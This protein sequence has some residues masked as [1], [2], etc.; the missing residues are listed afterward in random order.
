MEKVFLS[1][2]YRT[3]ILAWEKILVDSIFR[4][5]RLVTNGAQRDVRF[6]LFSSESRTLSAHFSTNLWQDTERVSLRDR[7]HFHDNDVH[8]A[9]EKK[10]YRK[11]RTNTNVV[12]GWMCLVSPRPVF[13]GYNSNVS[14]P[15][16]CT[17]NSQVRWAKRF[18]N[19]NI[20]F[21]GNASSPFSFSSF[22]V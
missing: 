12:T 15:H 4:S 14:L 8:H 2:R 10:R 21:I 1:Q 19:G 9:G 22:L 18:H 20:D 11:D 5:D 6:S 13:G 17:G 3:L 16:Y 7:T